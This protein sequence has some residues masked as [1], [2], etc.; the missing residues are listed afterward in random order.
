[1]TPVSPT[2]TTAD[3]SIQ[4]LAEVSTLSVRPGGPIPFH[5]SASESLRES[6]FERDVL[7]LDRQ[8]FTAAMRLTHNT[9]DA[10]DLVQEVM[11]R[12][13]ASFDSFRDGT[14]LKAWLYRILRNTWI[15]QHR[16]K[17]SRPDELSV[18]CISEPQLAA[19]IL[20]ASKASPSAE[21]SALDSVTD[22][23]VTT[24][25]AALREDV[26][27][28]VYYADVL[29]FSCKE[30]AVITNC[31]IGTVM[32]RLHRGRKR[33]RTSLIAVATRRGFVPEQRCITPSAPAA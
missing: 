18:E 8:L 32:S 20:R 3:A 2:R 11:L 12:A 17:K 9:H 16:K 5:D 19:V 22:E 15:S 25:L 1:M 14:S 6:R 33:L 7:P 4:M 29:E 27:T 26:R 23:E 30:I 21:D 10:E 28:T 24:A 13:Y 31:P